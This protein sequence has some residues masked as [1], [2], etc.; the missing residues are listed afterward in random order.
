VSIRL[1]VILPYLILTL[2]VAVTG[3]YVVTRLV[4]NSLEERLTNQ[5]LEA[6]RVVSDDFARQEINH[7]E[8]ARILAFT[9]G[10]GEALV[11]ADGEALLRLAQPVAAGLGLESVALI[12]SQGNELLYLARGEAGLERRVQNS[13]LQDS[14]M[15]AELLL[16][17]NAQSAPRRS[18]A[19]NAVEGRYLYYSTLPVE[20]NNRLAG[21]VVVGTS[22]ETLVPYLKSTSLADVILYDEAGRAIATTL[23]GQN[24]ADLLA[25]LSIPAEMRQKILASAGNVEG[26]NFEIEGRWYSLAYSPLRVGSDRLGIFAVVL[27]LDF[28]LQ[29]GTVSR[30]NSILLFAG[31]MLGVIAVGYGISRLL[32]NPIYALV[33]ASQAITSGDLSQR[34]GVKSSDE[35]GVLA[36]TFDEMTARLQQRTIELERANQTLA[37]MDKTIT[38]KLS[39]LTTCQGGFIQRLG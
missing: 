35:I 13:G 29:P 25:G 16:T 14:A 17:G 7:I 38:H 2:L 6:G 31:A 18:L 3:V 8:A 24:S 19:Y 5:L 34:T 26:K 39:T 1:K 9:S 30:N 4:A 15:V 21:L 11:A 12:D 28:V 10:V 36:N 27:P 32:V 20:Y 23:G 37:Q 33:R 22:F